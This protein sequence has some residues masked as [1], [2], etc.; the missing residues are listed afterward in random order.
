MIDPQLIQHIFTNLISNAVKYSN[1]EGVVTITLTC[2]DKTFY[3]NVKDQGIGIREED[4]SNLFDFFFRGENVGGVKGTGI[5]LAIVK[6]SVKAHG[7]QIEFIE[8]ISGGNIRLALNFV[9][10][11]GSICVSR[12]S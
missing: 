9:K 3:F 2:T 6:Q 12:R 1:G 11:F 10:S 7:G 4:Q 8:N 5:G